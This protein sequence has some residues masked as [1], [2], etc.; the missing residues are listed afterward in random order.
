M[1]ALLGLATS[2]I[3]S[4]L[5]VVER[6]RIV[7]AELTYGEKLAPSFPSWLVAGTKPPRL[8]WLLKKDIPPLY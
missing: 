1:I 6:G 5:L 8:A 2:L 7:L 3:S 4:C